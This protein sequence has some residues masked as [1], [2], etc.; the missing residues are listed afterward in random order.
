MLRF[1]AMRRLRPKRGRKIDEAPF[2]FQRRRLS[3][4]VE[5]ENKRVLIAKRRRRAFL[6]Y[7][8]PSIRTQM[9]NPAGPFTNDW[10]VRASV[11]SPAAA[12]ERMRIFH[13]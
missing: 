1:Y 13:N 11:S 6:P 4:V 9:H 8:V 5:F 7:A 3:V 2:D 10:G 12:I